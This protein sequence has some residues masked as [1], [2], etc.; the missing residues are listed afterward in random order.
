[1]KSYHGDNLR[2]NNNNFRGDCINAGQQLTY[3]SVGAHHKNTIVE[4]KTKYVCYG[5][6]TVLFHTKK[7]CPKVISTTLWPYTIQAVVE[8]HNQLA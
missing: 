3:C 6:S 4:S 8:R 5:A 2:F 1:M 7:K